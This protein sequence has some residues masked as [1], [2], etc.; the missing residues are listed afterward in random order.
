MPVRHD[1]QCKEGHITTLWS[2]AEA[3][4]CGE[5]GSE[6]LKKVF[7]E[8]PMIGTDKPAKVDALVRQEFDARGITNI[9]GGG[10]EGD[11]EKVSYKSTPEQLAAAKIERD[12]PQLKQPAPI[13][14]IG[15]Q[16]QQRWSNIGVKGIINSGLGNTPEHE[17]TKAAIVNAGRNDRLLTNRVFRKD[18]E[19]LQVKRG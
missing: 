7:I 10:H 16:V 5:C 9:Q 12:F 6:Y 8:P 17:R 19:N 13:Q 2:D 4:C 3:R 18:P 11:Q 1:F 15:R 14:Q